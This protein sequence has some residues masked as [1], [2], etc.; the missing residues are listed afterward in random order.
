MATS[1]VNLKQTAVNQA[2]ALAAAG[3]AGGQFE[4]MGEAV[5]FVLATADTLFDS[6]EQQWEDA[7]VTAATSTQPTAAAEKVDPADEKF[8]WGKKSGQT[9]AQVYS[10]DQSYLD[11]LVHK[12][13]N[14]ARSKMR[15]AAKAYIESLK[16][17]V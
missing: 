7:P 1:K 4:T 11:W 14:P 16:A 13:T 17:G 12:D 2:G 5:D 8:T 10:D 9:I 3:V 6:L 15:D